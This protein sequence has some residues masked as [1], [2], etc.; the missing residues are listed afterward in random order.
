MAE[1]KYRSQ[2][3]PGNIYIGHTTP[4]RSA[5]WNVRRS[6]RK[7]MGGRDV[8]DAEQPSA[9]A[10]SKVRHIYRKVDEFTAAFFPGLVKQTTKKVALARV[11]DMINELEYTIVEKDE[12]RPWGAFY[13][14]SDEQTD[15]FLAEFFPGLTLEEARLGQPDVKLSPKF[16]L[17]CPGQRLSWQYHHRRAERWHFMLA[18]SYYKS[19]TDEQGEKVSAPAGT[20]VQFAEGERH[21]LCS[22]DDERYTLVAEIWQHTVPTESSDEA[23]IVRLADDYSRN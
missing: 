8:L 14:L 11:E 12:E 4:L 2:H 18:G 19:L 22:A 5:V 21:R 20:I 7:V 15:R 17:V 16:L 1:T 3:Q 10:R 13:R 6:L 9:T 23:D